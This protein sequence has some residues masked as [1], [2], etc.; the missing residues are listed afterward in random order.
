MESEQLLDLFKAL[1]LLLQLLELFILLF[2]VKSDQLRLD[3][4]ALVPMT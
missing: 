1:V 4:G 3:P 2:E